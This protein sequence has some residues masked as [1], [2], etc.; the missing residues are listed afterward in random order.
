[1]NQFITFLSAILA[2]YG[3]FELF[4][5]AVQANKERRPCVIIQIAA[6]FGFCIWAIIDKNIASWPIF[7]ALLFIVSD[8]LQTRLMS[9]K[10]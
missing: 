6:G 1:M 9:K 5:M 4:L 8:R 10:R 7:L 2:S 3:V